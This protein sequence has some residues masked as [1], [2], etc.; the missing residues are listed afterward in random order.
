MK[1]VRGQMRVRTLLGAAVTVGALLC[2]DGAR[3]QEADPAHFSLSGFGTIGVAHSSE[4][5][6]QNPETVEQ[7]ILHRRHIRNPLHGLK[8]HFEGGE[9]LTNF[10]VQIVGELP[11][12]LFL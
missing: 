1:T 2:S 11:T 10:V 8:I 6:V 5:R 3:A 12:F 9:C 7:R 4:Q